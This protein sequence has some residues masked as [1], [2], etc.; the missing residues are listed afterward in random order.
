MV[1]RG[2]A[3]P[4]SA[5]VQD[6]A[7]STAPHL[8][9]RLRRA[10]AEHGDRPALHW[11]ET[12]LTWSALDARVTAV[13]RALARAVPA[14][15]DPDAVPAGSDPAADAVPARVAIALPNTPDFVV[16]FLATLRAGL[17][18]VP[19]NPGFTA[20]ELRH[21]LADSGAAL[22]LATG[23][24]A[25]RVATV[26]GDL[27]ALRAVHTTL[28]EE[29]GESPA[30]AGGDL[31]V[32]LY[33]SGTEGRPKGAMLT[34]RALAANHD[35]ID[36]IEPPVV[37]PDDTVLLALPLF[38]AYG[39][40]SGLGA[41]VHHGATGVLVDEPGPGCALDEIARHRVSV[42]VGVPSMFLAWSAADA[43]A[44]VAAMASVRVAVCGAAPLDPAT[45]ARFTEVTGHPVHVGYGLTE[46]A[47]V[48]TSTLVGGEPKPGSIGRP[49]PGVEVRLVGADGTD[50]WRD[51][52]AEPDDDP[53][54]SWPA[55]PSSGTDPGQIVAR[56]A[57]LFTGYW[58]DGRGGPDADG[59]WATGDVAYADADG[60]LFLVDRLGELIL[61]NGFNVYPHEVELVLDAH[62]GVA[63]SAVLGVP[64]PRTG[65]TVRA[66]VVPAAGQSV[67][68]EDLLA[69]CARNL[70]RFK[71]PTAVE[72]VDE[73]PYS[74]I[75]K[76]RKTQLRSV[77]AARS[78][79]VPDVP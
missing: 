14:G 11:R 22:L 54:E 18:A 62:P 64:H 30:R 28:P 78:P 33:T 26:A 40:N 50:L 13:A 16:A 31:A 58:P 72:F 12:T 70:A 44:V 19:V 15:S 1:R 42:L 65:E 76:V 52:V 36:R 37:G 38:H 27:P 79:E 23:E 53:D 43:D 4:D 7:D 39:L 8:A 25:E 32:L 59:W 60:D 20:R 63:G 56:G 73:L 47:P 5:T 34:H 9:D 6:A 17:V 24:V 2:G 74:V 45:A 57:N 75:G 29:V 21:V 55:D 67:T 66:Y 61:V 68:G 69:H 46:T 48:L 10:A 3:V 71:C 49:L 77:P 35:Q 41:V 51:G